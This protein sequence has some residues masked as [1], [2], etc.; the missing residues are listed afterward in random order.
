MNRLTNR[1]VMNE[2]RMTVILKSQEWG[3][4][5][6]GGT[7]AAQRAFGVLPHIVGCHCACKACDSG[8]LADP[9]CNELWNRLSAQGCLYPTSKAIACVRV[10][11]PLRI[12]AATSV[13]TQLM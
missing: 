4:A 10:D 12:V 6:D 13:S 1:Q 5:V 7:Y 9:R 8:T 11:E 2:W 3:I